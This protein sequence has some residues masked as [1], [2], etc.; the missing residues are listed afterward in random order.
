MEELAELMCVNYQLIYKLVR[1][2]EIP[3][4]RL[5]KVYRVSRRDLD[6]YL[7]QSKSHASGVCSVCGNTYNSRLSLKH[8]CTQCDELICVDCWSRKKVHV[9]PAHG[10]GSAVKLR[11][12]KKQS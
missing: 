9:C 3:A 4:A 5:G 10:S 2:G 8:T 6:A 11:E 7:Q 1:S 12:N